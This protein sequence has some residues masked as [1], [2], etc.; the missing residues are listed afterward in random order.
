MIFVRFGYKKS[1]GS[2]FFGAWADLHWNCERSFYGCDMSGIL[3]H[4][5][6]LP[7]VKQFYALSQNNQQLFLFVCLFCFV[8]FFSLKN[9]MINLKQVVWEESPKWHWN[10]CSPSGSWVIDQN[11]QKLF[12]S[13]IQEMFD[14]LKFIVIVEFL[15]QFILGSLYISFFS[16][17]C[18]SPVGYSHIKANGDVPL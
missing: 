10:V 18:S 6:Q 7:P 9:N 4:F 16:S 14:L 11:M 17:K 13:I 15:R 5:C 2:S 12:W 3:F 8:L 1:L